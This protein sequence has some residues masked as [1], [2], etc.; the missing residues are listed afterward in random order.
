MNPSLNFT[1]L[2]I[3]ISFL[4]VCYYYPVFGQ[5]QISDQHFYA[6]GSKNR[7][8]AE[9]EPVT[10]TM[11]TWPLCV[12]HKLAVEL[13]NDNHLYTLV[14]NET[15]IQEAGYWYT[16][17]GIDP[18]RTTFI[19]AKQ[20]IDAWWTRDWGPGAVF[21]PD[22]NLYLGDGKYIFATPVSALDCNDSL[23]F[24][25]KD[26][27]QNIIKTETDDNATISIGKSLG[28]PV[29]DLP[30]INTGGN[31]MT[32]GLGSAF[33]S[34]IILNENR[35]FN[36]PD[37]TF[38]KLNDSLSGFKK[39]HILSNF[40]KQGIQH[41]DCLM[42][43]LD[44]EKILVAEPPKDHELYPIYEHIVQHE[45][46]TLTSA[47]GRPYEILRLKTGRYHEDQLAAYTN[48]IIVNKTIYVPLFNIRED[49]MALKTWQEVMPGYTVKG[50]TF[51]LEDEPLMSEAMKNNYS[52]G[53]GWTHGDALHCR[54]RALWDPE[55]LYMSVKKIP[56]NINYG[57]QLKVYV[58]IIDYSKKGLI[59]ESPKL[60][61]RIKGDKNWESVLL[62]SEGKNQHFS[63]VLPVK[64]PNTSL[65]YYISA[66]SKSGKTESKP[67]TAPK[68]YYSVLINK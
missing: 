3:L 17:W 20:G 45:L 47:Y 50:F 41:I 19:Q 4:V 62:T 39:Y 33:S 6:Q 42:K 30:F 24:L 38:F 11:I 5:S 18:A 27:H 37:S 55:M 10:G 26:E 58:T 66:S 59:P 15:D 56:T 53:Y 34:C 21:G 36:I 9:W 23:M 43:L 46:K 12:P 16:K 7:T 1:K 61:W 60:Y 22:G 8:A 64:K 65:E 52:T 14:D 35:F 63:G 68:G 31:V 29:L 54:T 40:E 13:A 28:I 44:E 2:Y 32:D 25:Y 48:S 67:P 49:S 51:F 57:E